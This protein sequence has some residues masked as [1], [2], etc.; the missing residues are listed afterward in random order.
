MSPT[1]EWKNLKKLW[2]NIHNFS[3]LCSVT[4]ELKLFKEIWGER[5]HIS[6]LSNRELKYFDIKY[7]AHV[8]AKSKWGGGRLLKDNIILL[9]PEEHNL[10]DQGTVAQ[11]ATYAEK[12]GCDWNKIEELK[13]NLYDYRRISQDESP[14]L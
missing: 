2:S 13:Q 1:I 6:F 4:G 11:R 3:Y 8:I 9:H 12:W 7:F 5:P 14:T 10:L